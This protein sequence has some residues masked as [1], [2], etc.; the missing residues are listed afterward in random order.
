MSK[1][2][3]KVRFHLAQ[4]ENYMKWQITDTSTKDVRYVDPLKYFLKMNDCRLRNHPKTAQRIFNGE[5]KTVCAWVDAQHVEV[6]P[7]DW[8]P[9]SPERVASISYNPRVQPCWVD[10]YGNNCDNMHAFTIYSHKRD[11][12]STTPYSI[13]S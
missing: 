7:H 11:L 6:I 13:E 1:F 9:L 12:Y 3:Y 10:Y 4:G 2:R 5:N 8:L